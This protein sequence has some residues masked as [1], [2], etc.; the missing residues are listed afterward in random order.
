MKRDM[1]FIL[2]IVSLLLII[3]TYT[4]LG[5]NENV[6]TRGP[7]KAIGKELIAISPLKHILPI[8]SVISIVVFAVVILIKPKIRVEK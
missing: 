8:V 6:T 7:Y 2:S 5:Q 1:V 3:N 4:T